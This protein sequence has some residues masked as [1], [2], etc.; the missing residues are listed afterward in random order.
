MDIPRMAG[1][2]AGSSV[3]PRSDEARGRVSDAM[4]ISGLPGAVAEHLPPPAEAAR[5]VAM[6][7]AAFRVVALTRRPAVRV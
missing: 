6:R 3:A 7:R 2:A 4:A 1:A 5:L